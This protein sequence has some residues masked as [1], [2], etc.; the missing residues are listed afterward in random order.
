[1]TELLK[2]YFVN[3]S[4][5]C[6]LQGLGKTLQTISL[7][8]Y[9]K[10]F[11]GISGPHLVVVPKSTLHNWMNEFRKWCPVLRP[12]KFHGNQEE[13]VGPP[14]DCS[15]G[16]LQL[17]IARGGFAYRQLHPDRMCMLKSKLADCLG[18]SAGVKPL[19]FPPAVPSCAK[20]R[21]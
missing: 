6:L 10:E 7:L 5:I 15:L 19:H 17:Q 11:R 12:I 8:G 16:S 21:L 9:L 3:T 4:S 13:R 14:L 20:L 2:I 1:M 18:A